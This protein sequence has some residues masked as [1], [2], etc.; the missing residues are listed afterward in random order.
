MTIKILQIIPADGWWAK[1]SVV[2]ENNGKLNRYKK[3]LIGWALVQ[4]IDDDDDLPFVTGLDAHGQYVV[5][6]CEGETFDEY[7]HPDGLE[8]GVSSPL[9]TANRT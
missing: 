6:N 1:F 8:E 4:N 2:D 9:I 7:Y 5:E 3:R